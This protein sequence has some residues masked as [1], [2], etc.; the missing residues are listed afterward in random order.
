MAVVILLKA[1]LTISAPGMRSTRSGPPKQPPP[2]G[3][4]PAP[5]EEGEDKGSGTPTST[6]ASVLPPPPQMP[7]HP[8]AWGYMGVPNPNAAYPP[9]VPPAGP[10]GAYVT[11]H[12]PPPPPPPPPPGHRGYQ[13]WYGPGPSGPWP[14]PGGPGRLQCLSFNF[15]NF[16]TFI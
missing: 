9:A 11:G 6:A 14:H 10:P 4:A 12:Y 13:G 8:A 3:V 16:G 15:H 5:E 1:G 7:S 2:P